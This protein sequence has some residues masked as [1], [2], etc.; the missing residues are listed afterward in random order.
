[1]PGL[2]KEEA[3]AEIRRSKEVLEENLGHEVRSFAYV[4]G[5][6]NEPLE[7][8]VRACGY[9]AAFLTVPGTN[10][11]P[12]NPYRLERYNVEDY[13]LE[14]FSELLDG[15]ADFLALK[16]TRMGHRVKDLVSELLTGQR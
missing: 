4:K 2:P 14:Y 7:R 8:A 9:E 1:L 15:S 5:D 16:D 3:A 10:V 13:G 6:W 12:M 11:A